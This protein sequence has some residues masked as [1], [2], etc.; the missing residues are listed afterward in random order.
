ML[1]LDALSLA[2]YGSSRMR[3]SYA[4]ASSC[5]ACGTATC[6]AQGRSKVCLIHCAFPTPSINVG[7][8]EEI[9]VTMSPSQERLSNTTEDP[10]YLLVSNTPLTSLRSAIVHTRVHSWSYDTRSRLWRDD[11]VLERIGQRPRVE[12]CCAVLALSLI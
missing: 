11:A 7:V 8:Y 2:R 5:Q 9:W 10:L 1:L 3:C 6:I 12:R 4:L